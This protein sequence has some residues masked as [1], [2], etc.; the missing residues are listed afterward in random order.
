VY[1]IKSFDQIYEAA[2]E[3][4]SRLVERGRLT[5][6]RCAVNLR[7][8]NFLCIAACCPHL[9]GEDSDAVARR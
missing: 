7:E 5:V 9:S 1:A 3:V 2:K 4:E 8:M 6:R